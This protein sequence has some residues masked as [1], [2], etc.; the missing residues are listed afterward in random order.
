MLDIFKLFTANNYVVG[1][2]YPA[3]SRSCRATR[4]A[5]GH[6]LV[7]LKSSNQHKT[8]ERRTQDM[9]RGTVAIMLLALFLF[10]GLLVS[11]GGGGGGS[12]APPPSPPAFNLT[13]FWT[14]TETITGSNCIPAPSG[15]LPWT[16]NVT[17][18]SG[19]N[20]VYVTDT[21]SSGPAAAMTL[22]GTSLTYSG[23]RYNEAPSDCDIMTASYVVTMATATSFSNGSGTLTCSWATPTPGSCSIST[24]I[25][26]HK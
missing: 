14:M 18:A 20:T 22:S 12:S 8:K 11:C 9:K 17:Q 16:A 2:Q 3:S 6:W 5:I 10:T 4:K 13:G 7:S 15:T 26:G 21:R 25:S 1:I 24:T 23:E 19:S